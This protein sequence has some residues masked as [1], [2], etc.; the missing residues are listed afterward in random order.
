MQGLMSVYQQVTT[1]S[2]IVSSNSAPGAK[3]VSRRSLGKLPP[4]RFR[5]EIEGGEISNNP[6]SVIL[7]IAI[8][9]IVGTRKSRQRR[10]E[11]QADGSALERC[12]CLW[13][14]L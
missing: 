8:E 13:L 4:R 12:C 3:A 2:D 9:N 10:P 6:R 5:L 14:L 1:L 7:Y 11:F